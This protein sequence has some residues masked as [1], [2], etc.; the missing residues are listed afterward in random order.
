VAECGTLL[1]L[2]IDNI[3]IQ[4]HN[5]VGNTLLKNDECDFN[6]GRPCRTETSLGGLVS[7]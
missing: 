7:R 6:I 2:Q 3:A 4:S 1:K 5:I